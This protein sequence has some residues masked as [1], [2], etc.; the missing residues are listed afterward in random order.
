MD[1]AHLSRT[2]HAVYS[3]IPL[4]LLL[5]AVE[6]LCR[7]FPYRDFGGT[8]AGFVVPD[9]DLIWRLAPRAS[10]PLRT[11]ELGLRDT[12]YQADADVKI[13]VLG[14]S[15]SWGDAGIKHLR[16]VYP[17]RLEHLLARE[18]PSRTYEVINSGVPGYSTFQEATYLKL[19]GLPLKPDLVVL[20]FC[21]NDVVERYLTV[22]RYGGDN[23]FL[24]VDTRM[25]G[26]RMF[27]FL[28][29][30]SR[31]FERFFRLVQWRAR[32]REEYAVRNLANEPLGTHLEEAWQLVIEEL[33]EIR[34]TTQ[35]SQIPL[36]LVIAPY[37]F[38]L[39]DPERLR[40][41]QDRLIEYAISHGIPYVDLLPAFAAAPGS[42]PSRSLFNDPSHFSVAG[43]ELAAA[44]LG[45][46]IETML[47]S[48]EAPEK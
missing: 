32:K 18:D 35:Q 36:L 15:V 34:R 13:L 12:P 39:A 4:L 40:Q 44:L 17:Q 7:L 47:E 22:A 24:G 48:S 42:D 27:D 37:R 1:L 31:A 20:Q 6:A 38:Q 21:L 2:R 10:G 3:L 28:L 19:Y 23:V 25:A 33:E 5:V 11:N 30:H 41:P 9:R 16:E 14:D 29:R 43:H 26:S 45:E 8:A 46:R